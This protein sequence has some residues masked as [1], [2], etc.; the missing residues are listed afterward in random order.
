[1][2]VKL[3]WIHWHHKGKQQFSDPLVQSKNNDVFSCKEQIPGPDFQRS[4]RGTFKAGASRKK[5][6]AY[7]TFADRSFYWGIS[8]KELASTFAQITRW[9]LKEKKKRKFGFQNHFLVF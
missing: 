7:F 5:T 6:H 1:M 2:E 3:I 9:N 8:N 4:Q